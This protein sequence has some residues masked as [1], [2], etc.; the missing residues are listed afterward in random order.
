MAEVVGSAAPETERLVLIVPGVVGTPDSP[1]I[2]REA[3]G[4]TGLLAE[5]GSVVRLEPSSPDAERFEALGLDPDAFSLPLGPLW[6]AGL[7]CDPP[8]RSVEFCLTLGSI[9]D[10][11]V[12]VDVPEAQGP[13]SLAETLARLDTRSLRLVAGLS[14]QHGLVW[15]RGSL[16]LGST[17]WD[18][19]VGKF[20]REVWPEG[21]GEP[22][23][24]RLIEDSVELLG[25]QEWNRRLVD[26]GRPPLNVL[27]P[28][29]EGARRAMP[30]LALRR[31][32]AAEVESRDLG[33]AGL[34]RLVRYRHR[35]LGDCPPPDRPGTPARIVC[36]PPFDPARPGPGLDAWMRLGEGLVAPF[37]SRPGTSLFLALPGAGGGLAVQWPGVGKWPFDESTLAEPK[38]PIAPLSRW[39]GRFM[40]PQT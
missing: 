10:D 2:L 13:P 40:A 34:S 6:V 4:V 11:G 29:G 19:A 27:W 5:S 33:L 22:A 26:E 35:W 17:P 18:L 3:G 20:Y 8:E 38:S 30:D 25:S 39:V 31:G 15:E 16:D 21:D 23:L 32:V 9:R 28:W 7:G 14:T 1:G 37:V 36:M 24:R 12:L